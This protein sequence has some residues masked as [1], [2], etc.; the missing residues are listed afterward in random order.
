MQYMHSV[1][2]HHVVTSVLLLCW[3]G[4]RQACVDIGRDGAAFGENTEK[5]ATV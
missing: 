2:F 3:E 5:V 1:Q 4:F